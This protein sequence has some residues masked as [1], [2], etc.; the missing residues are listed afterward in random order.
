MADAADEVC[1]GVALLTAPHEDF[2]PA[3]VRGEPVGGVSVC[4]AGDV[5]DGEEPLRA[6]REYG[7]PALD[8]VQPMPYVAVQRMIDD[9]YPH[10][11]RNYWTGD[12]LTGLPGEAIDILCR[13]HLS[14]PS[15]ST[16]ILILPGGG[17]AARVPDGT[18]AI[19]QRHSRFNLH[20]TSL[21]PDATGDDAN[22][23]WT[24]ELSTAIRPFTTGRVYV[25][26]IG[27]E[28]RDRTVASFG[29]DY[30]RLQELKARYDP[31]NLFRGSQNIEP[32]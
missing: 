6:L 19:G 21:W 29:P 25:N 8:T 14:K 1:S 28:G 10:G 3:P 9:G 12:F 20:I 17:A 11:M 23:A 15:P 27:D 4:Y 5:A 2:V 30:P 16:Q 18:T 7:P 32:T 26:F 31:D 13:F 22:I 24:R